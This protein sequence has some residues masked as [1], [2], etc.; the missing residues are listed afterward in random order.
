MQLVSLQGNVYTAERDG[1]GDPKALRF[2]ENVPDIEIQLQANTVEHNESTSGQRLQDGRLILG[3]TA[4]IRM[5]MDYWTA[6]NI[7]MALYGTSATIA[8]GTVTGET[9]PTGLA[10]GDYV[11][12]ANQDIS[13]L[14][15]EDS[16][17][18]PVA[19][20][21]GTHYEITS[22][23]HGTVKIIADLSGFTAPFTADYT[24]AG[25]TNVAMF[26][27]APP[28]RWIKVDGTNTEDNTPVLAELYRVQ[29]DP[30]GSMNL[31]HN[32][33]YGTFEL[34]GSV[35]YDST[36]VSDT[37]LGQFGRMIEMAP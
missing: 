28:P 3:K 16:A 7:A 10:Q 23:K 36:K 21:L 37:V 13:A 27:T 5:V 12:L 24:Y 6:E 35:L 14:T 15:I 1:N 9:L 33:G 20:T 34:T 22:A 17:G 32:D 29:F 30:V 31:I 11:R 2:L 19:L 18:T 4:S 25:G 26:D 8:G